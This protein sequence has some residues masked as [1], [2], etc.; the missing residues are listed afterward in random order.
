[1]KKMKKKLS[2]FLALVFCM[3]AG[4]TGSVN[5]Y[6]E[7]PSIIDINVDQDDLLDVVLTLGRSD[8]QLTTLQTDLL[9]ALVAKG[10]PQNKI[11]IQAVESS[12]VSAGNTTAGWEI[13]DHTNFNDSSVIPYFRPYYNEINGNYTL[14]KHIVPVVNGSTTNIDFYGYGAPGYKDFMYMP[15]TDT[16]KKTFDFTIKEGTVYDALNGAGFLFNTNMTSNSN[17]ASR[18]MSGYLLFVNN[19]TPANPV[20]EIYKFSNID[21]NAF[22]NSAGTAIENY[23]GFTKIASYQGSKLTERIVKIEATADLFKMWN[24]STL[25]NWTLTTGTTTTEVP[26]GVG[27]GAYGFGP[28]VGY[29]SHGCSLPTHFTFNN[30]SMSTESSKRF[31]EVIREPEWRDQ[32]KRFIINAE[33]GAVSDFSDPVALGE[34]LARLGNENIH[35]LGWGRDQLDGEAFI[36]KNN[37]NGLFVDKDV[38]ATDTYAKQIQALAQYIYEKYVDGIKNDTETLIYGKPSAMSITPETEKTNTVDE[39]WPNGKWFINHD[40]LFYDNPTGVVPYDELYLNNLDISFPETGKYDIYYQGVL[41]KTVFVHRQPVA[42]FSVALDGD[43]KVT[44]TDNSFDPDKESQ[45]DKGIAS[46]NWSY[47]ETTASSWTAGKPNTFALNKNYIIK[48][49]VTDELGVESS[50]Y[51]R[52]VSTATSAGSSTPIGEFKVIPGRLLSYVSET[53]QYAD[54]SYDPEGENITTRLWKVFLEGTEIYSGTTPKTSFAGAAAGTYKITLA[55]QNQGGIWSETVARYLTVVRDDAAPTASINV[56]NGTYNT[57]K[58]PQITFTEE[59]GGSGFSNRFVKVTNSSTAP[60]DWGSMGTNE[61]YSVTLNNLG[62]NYLH[63]K[64]FDYAGNSRVGYF[65]PIQLADNTQPSAPN[66]TYDPAYI[67]GNWSKDTLRVSAEGSTDDFTLSDNLRYEVSLNGGTYI[68]RKS[69]DVSTEGIHTVDFRVT[70][71]SGNSRI[72]RKTIRLDV[73][74]PEVSLTMTSGGETYLDNT[75]S[76]QPVSIALTGEDSGGSGQSNCSYKID[77]GTWQNGSSYTFSESGE[78]VLYYRGMDN[79]GNYSSVGEASIRVDLDEPEVFEITATSNTIDSIT[80]AAE[81]TDLLSGVSGN[82]YRI[83]D[84][85]HWSLWK[86]TVFETLEGYSRGQIVD[87][88][89]QVLDR[90]GNLRTVE[91]QTQVLSNSMPTGVEDT[92][93]LLEDASRL[94]LNLLDNDVD[95]DLSTEQGDQLTVKYITPLSNPLAGVLT[96]D[97]G[98]VHFTPAGNWNGSVTFEYVLEDSMGAEGEGK[99]T[100]EVTPVND[101][102]TAI[103]EEIVFMEDDAFQA[104]AL[105]LNDLDPDYGDTL[106]EVLSVKSISAL[107]NPL[108]GKLTLVNGVVGFI[109]APNFNGIASFIYTIE[110]SKGSI[111]SAMVALRVLEVNDAPVLKDDSART[112]YG[113]AVSIGVL[114]NDQDIDTPILK[115]FQVSAPKNGR[116]NIQGS[117]IVY[118]PNQGF[119]GTDT[120]TYWVKDGGFLRSAEVAVLVEYPAF[121]RTTTAV[122]DPKPEEENGEKKSSDIR[123]LTPP[124]K[125]EAT[126]QGGSIFYTPESGKKGIDSYRFV[127]TVGGTEVE[128]LAII[129]IDPATGKASTLGYGLPLREKAFTLF[130]NGEIII[131]LAKYIE[132]F[133]QATH[134]QINGEV[135]QGITR[136]EGGNLIYTPDRDYTGNDG[137][138]VTLTLGQ[139]EISYALSFAVLDKEAEPLIS[140]I[141]VLGWLIAAVFL[142]FNYRKHQVFYKGIRSRLI[143]YIIG[144]V[145]L[146]VTLCLLRLLWGYIPS[147]AIVVGYLLFTYLYSG[148]GART[149]GKDGKNTEK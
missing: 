55:V 57:T 127:Q 17:L 99:V 4:L 139:E 56:S 84:G 76:G 85:S 66:F 130:K 92:F 12:S 135:T 53:V 143:L 11:K 22:H 89:V 28:L 42:N 44:I 132:G 46:T 115:L 149:M 148:H 7:E 80:I 9:A 25:V 108:A 48:E 24:N 13:Y 1:M 141:C 122:F 82:A 72:T 96:L 15:N 144:S 61:I 94:E 107:S 142:F 123:I 124:G 133:E 19:A 109:P 81:A 113:E 106:G 71:E 146:L 39:N 120:F 70:D 38:T 77:D 32:S 60:T 128:Y 147:I 37:G 36:A 52:F 65:G 62:T 95:N 33:D 6:A 21:V 145:L 30:V 86:S 90:V 31:S 10:V 54:T 119:V 18:T 87:L 129:V 51:L 49:V 100:L 126:I 121:V 43:L 137:T 136:I 41:V 91:L 58:T 105:T 125:G 112:L 83:Y 97:E 47:K 5:I 134:L 104:L 3:S 35:Y 14:N 63:Y 131:P 16:G 73:T 29:L 45:V 102:P 67:E 59:M 2:L 27:F 101:A 23:T 74:I 8:S 138:L 103:T 114:D 116:A 140:W 68:E 98:K 88:K 75:W 111:S 118:T 34:I 69:V 117:N 40:P 26:L 64:V 20:I 79:A 93:T 50:P 110:D 78:Y